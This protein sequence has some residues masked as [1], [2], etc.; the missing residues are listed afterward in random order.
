MEERKGYVTNIIYRNVENGYTVFELEQSNGEEE[1][2]VGT[3]PFINEGEYVKVTGEM[4]QHPV[5]MEQ[6]KVRSFE[7]QAPDNETA[8]LRYLG[9]GAIAGVRGGLAKRIVDKFGG[10]TFEIIEQEP[11]RLAE[12]KGISEKMARSIGEQFEEKIRLFD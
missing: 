3:L 10:K 2:C 1:T 12:V 8:M 6:L 11:E 9:S 5:Y 4:V 7:V